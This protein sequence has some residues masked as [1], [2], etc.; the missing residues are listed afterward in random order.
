[1]W[2]TFRGAETAMSYLRTV[3]TRRL[4]VLCAAVVL[5]AGAVTAIA[6]AATGV[7]HQAAAQAPRP[8]GSGCAQRATDQGRHGADL[9]HQPARRLGD[10]A[11]V[12]I[13]C[14]L[15]RR[16]GCGR[17]A[18]ACGSSSRPRPIPV[19]GD[20][21]VLVDGRN[22]T[23]YESGSRTAYRTLLPKDRG[24]GGAVPS[25]AR[26]QQAITRLSRRVGALGRDPEQRR[27]PRRLHRARRAARERRPP[28][29]R[30]G[31]VGRRQRRAAARRRVRGRA[32]PRRCSS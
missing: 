13:R 10:A 31:V 22:L 17:P 6:L 23:V 27:G 9:L 3:T 5:A 7:G 18:T 25:L 2:S 21:Q 11:R 30:R 14:S 19:A 24:R 15:A 8:G 1:M 26:I 32:T 20:V 16:G 29:R 4:L 12:L 28:R